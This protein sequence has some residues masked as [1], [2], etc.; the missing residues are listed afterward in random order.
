M[1][2][3][4]T[5]EANYIQ[6]MVSLMCAVVSLHTKSATNVSQQMILTPWPSPNRA[7]AG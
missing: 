7:A 5:T 4:Q 2:T 1:M 6:T 3:R